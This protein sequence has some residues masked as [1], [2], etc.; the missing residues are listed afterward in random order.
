MASNFQ[1]Q[2]AINQ[3]GAITDSLNSVTNKVDFVSQNKSIAVN[4][5]RVDICREANIKGDLNINIT[6]DIKN[7]SQLDVSQTMNSINYLKSEI[8][9]KIAQLVQQLAS[10]K[11]G[12]G[13]VAANDM[14]QKQLNV[15]DIISEIA[16]ET[17]NNMSGVCESYLESLNNG[18]VRI[19]GVIGGNV[20]LDTQQK[21]RNNA[22]TSCIMQALFNTIQSNKTV[23]DILQKAD[24]TEKSVQEG[25]TGFIWII[26][27]LVVAIGAVLIVY[28]IVKRKKENE[29]KKIQNPS[30]N[31]NI[32]VQKNP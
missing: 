8:S 16:N 30:S 21:I 7:F 19:C 12:W 31:V 15:S 17:V 23:N 24:Q 13:A 11:Q 14:I 6:Q 32:P 4:Q 25:I 9:N 5:F 1:S 18:V 28:A 22:V 29:A 3:I 2:S 10:S 20:N 27:A 26:I